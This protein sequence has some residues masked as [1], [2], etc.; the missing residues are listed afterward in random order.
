[1]LLPDP[2]R[3][4]EIKFV[5]DKSMPYNARL[6]S[7]ALLLIAGFAVQIL[8]SQF[9]S[10]IAI[11]AI[12]LLVASLFVVVEGYTNS[13]GR[14]SSKQ[15]WRAGDKEQLEKIV[16][17]SKKTK[18]WD[19]SLIDITCGRGFMM[20]LFI[21]AILIISF[22]VLTGNGYFQLGILVVVDGVVLLFPHWITGVRRI[23]TNDALVVKVENLLNV[24]SIWEKIKDKDETMNV[25][26]EIA[27]AEKGEV[28]TN[29]KLILQKTPLG[30][31]FYGLQIQVVLNNVQ[32]KDFPYLYCVIVAKNEFGLKKLFSSGKM[33]EEN[34]QKPV[35]FWEKLVS[36]AVPEIVTEWKNDDGMDIVVM[37]QETTKTSGYHTNPKAVEHIFRFALSKMRK[38][39]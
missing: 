8:L 30:A 23:L 5:I 13:P 21:I 33:E 18:T 14:Q 6:A 36:A 35:S 37:R 24:Y 34:S 17:V 28:P 16:A 38:L 7:M 26:V 1:M 11:G 25:Q 39:S 29:A 2:K 10:G 22:I 3:R 4:G 9:I 12:L 31:S 32:G 19:Q 20:L 15:E 27:K